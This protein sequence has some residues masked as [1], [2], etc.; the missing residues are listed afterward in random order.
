[1]REVATQLRA[2]DF[3][4]PLLSADSGFLRRPILTDALRYMH[5]ARFRQ[6]CPLEDAIKFHAFA[7]LEALAVRVTNNVWHSSRTSTFLTGS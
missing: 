2:Q 3:T 4:K 1:L 6:K 7:P 5:G